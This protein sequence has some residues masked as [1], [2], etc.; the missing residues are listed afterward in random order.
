M[1]K[2]ALEKT[3]EIKRQLR[4]TDRELVHLHELQWVYS[5]RMLKFGMLSWIFGLA[6]FFTSV[7][8]IDSRLLG[9]SYNVW[10]P[11]LI[12]ALAVPAIITVVMIQKFAT[13]IKYLERLR[14]DLLGKYEKAILKRVDK[15]ITEG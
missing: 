2:A 8:L 9:L 10:I 4:A 11:L 13:K 14:R 12:I 3:A 15:M 6:M 1:P 5:K 7:L